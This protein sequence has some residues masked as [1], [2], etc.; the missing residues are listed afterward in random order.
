M[1][2]GGRFF[3]LKRKCNAAQT[4]KISL[5]ST[6]EFKV[7]EA[8]LKNMLSKILRIATLYYS[9]GLLKPFKIRN[10]II[11]KLLRVPDPLI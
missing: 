1:A 4:D 5:S 8:L 11:I 9:I 10:K 2:Q 6:G 7:M 3:T